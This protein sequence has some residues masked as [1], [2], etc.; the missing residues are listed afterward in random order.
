[1]ICNK[2]V[3][4]LR[5]KVTLFLIGLMIIAMVSVGCSNSLKAEK[6]N[7]QNNN[8]DANDLTVAVS[9]I[10]QEAFVKAVAGDLVNVVTMIPPGNSPANYQPTPK[11]LEDFSN[12]S[13]YFSIG[14]PTEEANIL[15]KAKDL[16]NDI[17]VVSLADK[18]GEVYPHRFFS[19]DEA[20]E[21]DEH[22]EHDEEDDH[23]DIDH[24]EDHHH[25]GRDPHIWLS[26]KRV[27]VMINV[28]RD[29]LTALDP[30]NKEIYEENAENYIQELDSVDQEIKDIL[31]GVDQQSFIIY[32]PSFGY[33]ADD[34]GLNMVSIEESGKEATMKR[35]QY[36]IDYAKENNIKFVFYQAEFD[37]QQ[38]RTIAD[39]INGEVIQVNPLAFD[40]I[41]NMKKIAEKF[42]NILQ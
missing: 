29:E 2:E 4:D 17:K 38:A 21:H 10:P 39:E 13:I 12:S 11:E 18:V 23:D 1:M 40:Y 33:F 34:Y 31:S 25:E 32:H 14:V 5:R 30:S 27:R 41:D 22:D 8:E 3:L 24:E 6:N 35:L 26:P 37:S 15:P 28:I 36:V 20:H 16:N 19:E 42:N 9:V 7:P